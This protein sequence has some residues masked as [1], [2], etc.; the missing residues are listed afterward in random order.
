MRLLLAVDDAELEGQICRLF[1]AGIERREGA[2]FLRVALPGETAED[3][4]AWVVLLGARRLSRYLSRQPAKL[5]ALRERA[6]V[7]A[8]IE[9]VDP[10]EAM[11]AVRVADAVAFRAA[12][13]DRL[14]QIVDLM[15]YNHLA[16]PADLLPALLRGGL[17]HA[18]A[19]ALDATE[20]RVLDLLGEGCNDREIAARLGTG[21]ARAKYRVRTVLRK[22][23]L[24]NRTQAAV[25]AVTAF[26]ERAAPERRET[27]RRGEA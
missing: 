13:L 10:A 27:A 5:R 2:R 15:R 23:R 14:P 3:R 7:V 1:R 16:I 8:L 17:R 22:L 20:R 25:F 9:G 24:R 18:R 19:A 6:Q 4:G 26:R 11:D 12:N 21:V